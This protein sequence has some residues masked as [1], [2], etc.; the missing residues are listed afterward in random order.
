RSPERGI[1]SGCGITRSEPNVARAREAADGRLPS[2]L[3]T[4]GA[5]TGRSAV[6]G[7]VGEDVR[8]RAHRDARAA[9]AGVSPRGTGIERGTRDVDVC[10]W[11]ILRDEF[12]QE[13]ACHEHAR[14]TLPRDVADV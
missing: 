7:D 6:A 3:P 9:L 8:D 14:G 13:H 10:P 2:V 5:S 11:E 4:V 1:H 12:A